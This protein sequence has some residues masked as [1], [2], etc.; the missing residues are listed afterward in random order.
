[1]RSSRERNADL[2]VLAIA[3]AAV[4]FTGLVI[5]AFIYAAVNTSTDQA[6]CGRLP[7]GALT[8]IAD[9]VAQG[10]FFQT[11]GGSCS[12]WLATD[13]EGEIVAYKLNQPDG[14]EL[15]V[16]RGDF[17]C[18]EIVMDP[19]DLEQYPVTIEDIDGVDTVIVDLTEA[20]ATSV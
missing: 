17:V 13:D 10:P 15:N 18:D 11:G 19:V 20:T 3:T 4:L 1:M 7:V 14:C 16:E 5:A 8:G 6:V 9:D 12:F 2:K